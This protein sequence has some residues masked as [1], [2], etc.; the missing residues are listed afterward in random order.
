MAESVRARANRYARGDFTK[1]EL[2][3]LS[4]VLLADK[5]IDLATFGK[6]NKLSAKALFRIVFPVVTT[7]GRIAGNVALGAGRVLGSSAIGAAAPIVTNPYVAGTALG[8]G[9]LATPPGQALLEAAEERG[10]M[11][12]IRFEQGLTDFGV[13]AR[14]ALSAIAD[15]NAPIVGIRRSPAKSIYNKAVSTGMKA[16]KKSSSYGKKGVLSTPKKAFGFV[17]KTVSKLRRGKKVPS[18]GAS[19]VVKRSLGNIKITVRK[20]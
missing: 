12:R 20:P 4:G 18:K 11:D 2:T 15:L 16:L 5:A 13:E 1:R 10:R 19:G 14:S 17:A 6:L 3:T 7:T 9:A 8:L